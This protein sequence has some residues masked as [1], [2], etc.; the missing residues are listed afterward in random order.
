M[1]H[2]QRS[3]FST[4]SHTHQLPITRKVDNFSRGHELTQCLFR[5]WRRAIAG[6]GIC[7]VGYIHDTAL[8]TQCAP[9]I[10]RSAECQGCNADAAFIGPPVCTAPFRRVP[11]VYL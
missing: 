6:Y 5:L 1:H 11:F 10:I 9:A 7:S 8:A 3:L 4:T 2:S